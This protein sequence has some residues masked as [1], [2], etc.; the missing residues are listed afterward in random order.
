MGMA[1]TL[2]DDLKKTDVSSMLQ[3]TCCKKVDINSEFYLLHLFLPKKMY[4]KYRNN[5]PPG[6]SGIE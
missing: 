1:S 2:Q 5:N 3:G 4:V 6:I